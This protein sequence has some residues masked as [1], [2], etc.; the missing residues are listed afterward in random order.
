MTGIGT[1][2]YGECFGVVKVT[3]VIEIWYLSFLVM[4]SECMP[5]GGVEGARRV[6]IGCPKLDGWK[7]TSTDPNGEWFLS[8]G[9]S[10]ESGVV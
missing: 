2:V 9:G 6:V 1:I 8:G 10:L 5:K 7:I 3:G 4:E